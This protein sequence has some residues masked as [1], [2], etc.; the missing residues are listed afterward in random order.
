MLPLLSLAFLM[1]HILEVSLI[2]LLAATLQE[3]LQLT[4]I[5]NRQIGGVMKGNLL[6][7]ML[8]ASGILLVS[9]TYAQSCC[10]IEQGQHRGI[11]RCLA[12]SS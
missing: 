10:Q 7:S 11:G 6:A 1:G 8:L 5:Q 12:R 2:S 3:R 9:Q 4:S